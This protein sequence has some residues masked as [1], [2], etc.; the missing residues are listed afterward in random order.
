[1]SGICE[2]ASG[3]DSTNHHVEKGLPNRTFKS[4]DLKEYF[5]EDLFLFTHISAL[6]VKKDQLKEA[7]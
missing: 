2:Y 1:M 3:H 6:Q 5:K 7:G 4:M